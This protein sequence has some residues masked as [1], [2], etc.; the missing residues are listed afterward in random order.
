M[1]A[2]VR[3]MPRRHNIFITPIRG[4]CVLLL[5]AALAQPGLAEESVTT[6]IEKTGQALS[7]TEDALDAIRR[8]KTKLDTQVT[9]IKQEVLRVRRELV[10]AAA[11]A[12]DLEAHVSA[13]SYTHLRAHET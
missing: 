2:R 13:V 4:A 7:Q 5:L 3:P 10:D 9:E 8:A 11:E 1:R 6:H 12:Q